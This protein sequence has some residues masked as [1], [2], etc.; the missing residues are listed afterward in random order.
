MEFLWALQQMKAVS[1][2][3][4]AVGKDEPWATKFLQSRKFRS[5]RN[6]KI[7]ESSIKNGL[8]IEWWY[9]FGKN[10]TEGEKVRWLGNCVTCADVFEFNAYEVEE[11]RTDDM[12]VALPC[13]VCSSPLSL[14]QDVVPFKPTREQVEGW[15]ELGS[16]LTPKIERVHHQFSNEEIVFENGGSE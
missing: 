1:A 2:A 12:A 11:Q 13:P 8:T 16:R 6:A 14:K 4:I 9:E 7:L 5:F 3:A 10:L 15:K